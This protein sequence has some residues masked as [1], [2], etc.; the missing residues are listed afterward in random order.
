MKHLLF[1]LALP[2]APAAAVEQACE[3]RVWPAQASNAVTAGVLSNFGLLGAY[4]DMEANRDQTLHNQAALIEALGLPQQ[5]QAMVAM[6]LPR[7]LGMGGTRLV[8]ETKPIES[9]GAPKRAERMSASTASCYAEFIVSVNE[10]RKSAVLGSSLK[11][12]VT[13][14][15][16]RGRKL[17]AATAS[18]A[19]PLP[20]FPAS[21]PEDEPRARQAANDAF[22]ANLRALAKRFAKRR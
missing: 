16:Y 13:F 18:E 19:S 7:L 2:A 3:L 12:T 14:K 17:K 10:Y 20:R 22:A 5:A 1:A 6:D 8:F 4:A 21:G 11:T 9:R 15:D